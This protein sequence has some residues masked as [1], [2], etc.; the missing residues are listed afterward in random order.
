MKLPAAQRNSL[1][2]YGFSVL[3][4][5]SLTAVIDRTDPPYLPFF[6]DNY[7]GLSN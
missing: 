5:R 6:Y 7:R 4:P 1:G 3:V 2:R